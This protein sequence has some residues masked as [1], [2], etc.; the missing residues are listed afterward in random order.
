M[1]ADEGAG[2]A[3]TL[4]CTAA[5]TLAVC[6]LALAGLG[7]GDA[8][9]GAADRSGAARDVDG[10]GDGAVSFVRTTE[11]LLVLTASTMS[12]LSFGTGSVWPERSAAAVAS[13]AV[14]F[15]ATASADGTGELPVRL[16]DATARVLGLRGAGGSSAASGK[17][18][19]GASCALRLLPVLLAAAGSAS[20]LL[21]PAA[22]RLLLVA[23]RTDVDEARTEF[24]LEVT[25]SFAADPARAAVVMVVDAGRPLA[26]RAEAAVVAVLDVIFAE[27]ARA[28]PADLE[29]A[30]DC[31]GPDFA[32]VVAAAAGAFEAAL[33]TRGRLAVAARPA[34][35][36]AGAAA[37]AATAAPGFRLGCSTGAAWPSV[38]TTASGAT[39]TPWFAAHW[40]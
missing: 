4:T 11:R 5:C 1:G 21:W 34:A 8:E 10:A 22:G 3:D 35:A 7:R 19:P 2:A 29:A 25:L 23:V 26:A 27:A 39:K 30:S 37:A 18:E 6:E 17:G 12:S 15:A 36:D 24:T 40:K 28:T 31:A 20:A 14:A 33:A 32:A 9:S 38:K 16:R 13:A